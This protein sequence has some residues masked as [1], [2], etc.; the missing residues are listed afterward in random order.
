MQGVIC[1]EKIEEQRMIPNTKI[2]QTILEFGK[3]V[4]LQLPDNHTKEE[5]E[6]VIRIVISVWNAVVMD[7]WNKSNRFETE[8]LSAIENA[9]KEAQIEIKRL[10]KRKKNKYGSD[11]R[12]V[13]E[14]WVREQ[15]G[16]F[17]FGCEARLSV[18]N[19]PAEKTKH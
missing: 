12:A 3:P 16:E 6:F 1:L 2:S 9:P 4:I 8:L 14:H 19:A 5:F 18:E 13:G 11:P 15:N 10:L 17:I 7:G